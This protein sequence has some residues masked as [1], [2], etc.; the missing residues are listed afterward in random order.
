MSEPIVAEL[1]ADPVDSEPDR[2]FWFALGLAAL[3]QLLVIN[4]FSQG[5]ASFIALLLLWNIA[6]MAMAAVFYIA[7]ARSAA[8]GWLIAVAVWGL[9]S[10]VSVVL[11]RS[12]TAALGFLWAPLW[13]LVIFGPVGVGI[14][15]LRQRKLHAEAKSKQNGA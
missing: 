9:W 8:W 13:G 14:A 11:S 3:P 15:I 4:V 12:S 6:P 1:A 10:A 7:G 2:R 5:P